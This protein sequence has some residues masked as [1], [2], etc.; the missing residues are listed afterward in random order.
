MERVGDRWE[1]MEGSCSTGQ[2]PQWA[3]VPVEEEDLSLNNTRFLLSLQNTTWLPQ[4]LV[5]FYEVPSISHESYV[6][7]CVSHKM[8]RGSLCL[9]Q[10][11]CGFFCLSKTAMWLLVSLIKCYAAGSNSHKVPDIL[12]SHSGKIK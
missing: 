5:K 7:P 2:S 10:N 12:V 6:T 9:S 3:V 11:V 8:I 4:L 1:K